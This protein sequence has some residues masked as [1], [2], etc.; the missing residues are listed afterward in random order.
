MK[1]CAIVMILLFGVPIVFLVASLIISYV[2]ARKADQA[3]ANDYVESLR[4]IEAL[5]EEAKTNNR[6]IITATK[7]TAAR[8]S[9]LSSS[10][11]AE[12]RK[13]TDDSDFIVSMAVANATDSALLG[14]AIGGDPVGAIIGDSLNDD[15]SDRN[16]SS[17][18]HGFDHSSDSHSSY[19][20]D[21]SSS[22]WSSSDSSSSDWGSSDSSS[23]SDW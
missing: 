10:D 9:P 15:D 8:I 13:R 14:M 5:R 19:D 6:P 18:D 11:I 2:R 1:P 21:S 22:D 17:F 20:S 16:H 12:S 7:G 23:S 4:K 3:R